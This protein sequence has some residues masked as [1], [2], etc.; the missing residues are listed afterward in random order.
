MTD[1]QNLDSLV[2]GRRLRHYRRE[3]GLTLDE[4]GARV[5]KPGP[6]LSLLENGKKEPRLSLVMALASALGVEVSSLLDPNPPSRR[7]ALEIELLRL[8]ETPF[9]STLDLP[10][11]KPGSRLDSSGQRLSAPP[12]GD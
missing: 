9:F 6:S 1:S 11:I 4:L 10:T 2:F 7:D 12:S 3:A 8:Q 5:E